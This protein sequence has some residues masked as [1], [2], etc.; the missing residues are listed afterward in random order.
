MITVMILAHLL[1]D[2]LFQFNFIARWKARSILGVVAHGAIVTITTLVCAIIVMPAWWPWA[3]L[4]GLI[5]T[6]A[7]V[8]RAQLVHPTH[9]L[10]DLVYYLLDQAFHL[11]VIGVVVAWSSVPPLHQLSGTARWLADPRLL[12]YLICYLLLLNPAWVLLRFTVRGVWG[13]QAAPHL[14]QGEKYGPMI[15]RV[16]MTS[17][18]LAGQYFLVPLVLLPRRLASFR[19]Q[20]DGVSV[21]MLRLTGHWAETVLSVLTAVLV[22]LALRWT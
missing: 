21:V 14:G 2:Y 16:L 17:C 20:G 22:G 1:G 6:I 19:M 15:E 3:L 9:P 12:T 7:D 5:H 4:I 13:P 18:I 10:L 8:I 11:L